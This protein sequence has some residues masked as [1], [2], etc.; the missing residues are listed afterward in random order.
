MHS[1]KKRVSMG[2]GRVA[3]AWRTSPSSLS[4]LQGYMYM[5][6]GGLV[7]K[8]VDLDGP[9]IV[10]YYCAGGYARLNTICMFDAAAAA[11]LDAAAVR[12]RHAYV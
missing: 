2:V 3:L 12:S 11:V 6:R 10:T 5:Q 4:L 8:L 9:Y 1:Q 7:T